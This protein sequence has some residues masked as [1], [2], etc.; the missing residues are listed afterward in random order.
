MGLVGDVLRALPEL[1]QRWSTTLLIFT[2]AAT[3]LLSWRLWRFT[4]EPTMRPTEPKELP[5]WLPCEQAIPTCSISSN[6]LMTI[7]VF[8]DLL[9]LS[10]WSFALTT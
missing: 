9:D 3:L 2:G 1:E 7:V 4:I 10:R 6:Q 8:G 5:Y